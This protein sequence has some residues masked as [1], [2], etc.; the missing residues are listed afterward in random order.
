METFFTVYFVIGGLFAL[1]VII[2]IPREERSVSD[3]FVFFIAISIWP[4]VIWMS[5]RKH[6]KEYDKRM[7]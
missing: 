1:A 6:M 2:G 7:P 3:A 5:I 4:V